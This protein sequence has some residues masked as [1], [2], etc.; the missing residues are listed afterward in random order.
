MDFI[1]TIQIIDIFLCIQFLIFGL[2]PRTDALLNFI[3][4]LYGLSRCMHVN[5]KA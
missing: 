1:G 4:Q 5:F 3:V 2:R